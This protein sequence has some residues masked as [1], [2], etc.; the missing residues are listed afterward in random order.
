MHNNMLTETVLD[1]G[2]R[3][4]SINI[5]ALYKI[6]CNV[7]LRMETVVEVSQN[8]KLMSIS[9]PIFPVPNLC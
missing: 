8:V 5:P 6:V 3:A 7:Y 2:N 9:A 4:L 1:A